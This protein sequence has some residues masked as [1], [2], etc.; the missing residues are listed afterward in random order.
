MELFF[1]ICSSF[2]YLFIL[3]FQLSPSSFST[4]SNVAMVTVSYS[5][6]IP[7]FPYVSLVHP[8]FPPT[9]VAGWTVAIETDSFKRRAKKLSFSLTLPTALCFCSPRLSSL[10]SPLRIHLPPLPSCALPQSQ[11]NRPA[12]LFSFG[13]CCLLWMWKSCVPLNLEILVACLVCLIKDGL[14]RKRQVW[15]IQLDMTEF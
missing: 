2:L 15:I 14:W 8:H 6:C 7:L 12:L 11:A 10:Y 9:L 1:S 13:L 4:S 3:F 5:L